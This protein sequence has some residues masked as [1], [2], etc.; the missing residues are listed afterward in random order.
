[1]IARTDHWKNIYKTKD[2]EKV[3]WYQESPDISLELLSKIHAQP[4]QSVIDIGC[5]ASLL[6]DNIIEQGFRDITLLDLSSEALSIIKKRLG[7]KA[8]IPDYL[9]GDIT[10]TTLNKSYDI[11]HDRAVFHFLTNAGD[12]ENY[13]SRLMTNLSDKGR[14]IIGTFSLSGPNACS[15][16]D[17]VQYDEGKFTSELTGDLELE[18]S[19]INTHVTPGRSEQEYIYFIIKHNNT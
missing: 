1:M 12:R 8:N 5:G 2:H 7:E 16:L 15:G 6:V 3:G 4:E 11:W 9:T 10:R 19:V 17:V 14:A 13:M 18:Y